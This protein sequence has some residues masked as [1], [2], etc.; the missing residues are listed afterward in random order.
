MKLRTLLFPLAALTLAACIG[1][2][3]EPASVTADATEMIVDGSPE[4][5]GVIAFLNAPSTTLGVLDD[6]VPL[7]SHAASALVD[8]RDG[9][10]GVVG[11]SD[12][13]PYDDVFEILAVDNIGPKR[14]ETL[15]DYA[16]TMGFVP[17]GNDV[18]GVYDGVSFTVNEADAVLALV[19]DASLAMLDDTIGL[20]KRAAEA[21]F[22]A[23]PIE[24]VLELSKLYFVGKSALLTLK[25]WAVSTTLPSEGE[26]CEQGV[27]CASGLMCNGFPSGNHPK[28]GKCI[29]TTPLPGQ[30][31]ACG[32]FE[33][34]CNEGLE[35][36]GTTIYN[37]E[38]SCSPSWMVGSFQ[39]TE[40]VTIPDNDA[41]G[42]TTD[43][44]VYGL[45]TV[46]E[47]VVVT[48]YIDHPRPQDLHVEL[49]S[50]NGSSAVLWN[51]EQNPDAYTSETWG[52]ERDNYVN[53]LWTLKVIDSVAGEVGSLNGY[54]LLISSRWD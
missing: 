18:L 50:S 20:D 32:V 54:K 49:I 10:D 44:M 13:D 43:L 17:E 52:I 2:T 36:V 7:P 30:G 33:G 8:H 12:D 14:L 42:V 1:D 31:D 29:D 40:S 19:N 6:E 27:G 35:C 16:A 48:L 38:G 21:I 25:A 46:P 24:T 22:E 28:I 4:A 39:S 11:T 47:D 41:A 37:G 34:G 45:A 5:V 3:T 53:G 15:V 23:T 51:N 26:D 9:P